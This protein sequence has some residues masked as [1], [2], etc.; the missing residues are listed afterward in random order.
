M[1]PKQSN[2]QEGIVSIQSGED[3]TGKE[4][5][6]VALGSSGGVAVASLPTAITELTPYVV[7]EGA[8]SGEESKL[9]PLD[10]NRNVRIKAEGTGSAG[11]V[12]V[13]ADP[14]T[15]ADKGMVRALP[16]AAATYLAVGIAEEDFVDGQLVK[17]RPVGQREIVVT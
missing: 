7:E 8:A 3:L 12:V 1:S 14:G 5:F 10:P 6:L 13:M 17:I 11:D 4:A 15:S 9:R 16:A 2:T